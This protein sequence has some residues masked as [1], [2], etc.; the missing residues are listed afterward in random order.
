MQV[1]HWTVYD[2][3]ADVYSPDGYGDRILKPSAGKQ[4]AL[5]FQDVPST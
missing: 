1:F 2:G 3:S 4:L 5:G